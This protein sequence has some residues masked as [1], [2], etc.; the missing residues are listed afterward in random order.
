MTNATPAILEAR[1]V[2]KQF[3]GILA[4]DDVSLSLKPGEILAVVGENGAGKSTLMKIL[5][6][7]IQPSR[8]SISVDGKTIVFTHIDQALSAGVALIHQELNL[9]PNLDLGANIFLGREPRRFGMLAKS[10]MQQLAKGHMQRLGLEGSPSQRL[11]TLS[12]GKQQLVEIAKALAVDARVLI[13]DEPTS[14]LSQKEADR[15][16]QVVRQL[17]ERGIAIC[18]ISHRLHEVTELADR[19]V[20]LRDGKFVGELAGHEIERD[21]IVRMMVGR[22]ISQFFQRSPH[23]AGETALSARSLRTSAFPEESLDF[24]VRAGEIVGLA[25]LVGAGRSELLTTLFG[26]TPSVGG[27]MEVDGRSYAPKSSAEAI[28]AGVVLAPEDRRHTGLLLGKGVRWNLS[29]ASLKKKLN[30]RGFV[31]Q[32]AESLLCRKAI[33]RMHIKTAS[34]DSLVVTLSGGNQQKVVLGK[35]LATEP[36]VLLLDEPT[37]GIDVGSKS[38]IYGLIHDLAGHGVAIL[39]ASS[40]MEEILGLSDRVLVMNQGRI[41]GELPREDLSEASIMHLAVESSQL[42]EASHTS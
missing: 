28:S 32:R 17:R 9:A 24:D 13:M 21:R 8:G 14:S 27:S 41:T 34:D 7:V 12:I 3:G 1:G 20:V 37:R 15:L 26:I 18:Y 11:D 4:L 19:V 25:G 35:W 31:R 40:E 6:G 5:A 10:K 39:F 33:D 42:S 29:L 36:R 2:S 22:D 23:Q 38:E 16:Y 30:K